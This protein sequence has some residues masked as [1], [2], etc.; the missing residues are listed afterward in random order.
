MFSGFSIL[1]LNN[2]K[3]I[4]VMFIMLR[5][6]LGEVNGNTYKT[7]I[8]DDKVVQFTMPSSYYQRNV[9]EYDLYFSKGIKINIVVF[10]YD[11]WEYSDL[12][13]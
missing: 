9:G 13:I 3:F 7:Y 2:L 12:D 4:S 6:S 11:N 1:Q 8:S 5:F 10:L